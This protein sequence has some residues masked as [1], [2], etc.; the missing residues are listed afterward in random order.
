MPL[1]RLLDAVLR[2]LAGL[3]RSHGW[4]FSGERIE[5]GKKEDATAAVGLSYE[6]SPRGAGGTVRRNVPDYGKLQ[7]I[8]DD[9]LNELAS[10]ARTQLEE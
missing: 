4:E 5:V 9:L 3:F 10:Q 8:V 1:D 7:T 2:G 6:V